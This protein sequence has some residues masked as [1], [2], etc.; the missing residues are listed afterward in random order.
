MTE[1]SIQ[2]TD[3]DVPM[4]AKVQLDA[5]SYDRHHL[6]LITGDAIPALRC[7]P[8]DCIN[9]I[10][11]SPPYFWVRDYG[12]EN[13]IGHEDTVRQY[14]TRLADVFDEVLRVL[15]PNGVCYVNIGDTYYSGNGQPHGRDPRS[16]SRNFMRQKLRPVDRSGWDIPKKSLIGIPW[17]L[18]FE[19]QK[20]NWALR[21]DIIWARSN[22][23]SEPSA[24]DRPWRQHEHLFL[25]AKNRFYS[26]DR[27]ALGGDED[28]WNISIERSKFNKE[29][30]APFPT[31]LVERCIATGAPPGGRVLDPF[32]GSGTTVITAMHMGRSC[33]GVD[34]KADYV[35]EIER[36]ICE[37][38]AT[39]EPWEETLSF[40]ERP[41]VELNNW[42]GHLSNLRKPGGP[43]KG[44]IE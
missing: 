40:L 31:K 4:T 30:N 28:V 26:Y 43:S 9:V 27:S 19:M 5:F 11:T 25:F 38:G 3:S 22:A 36:V 16:P 33:I 20:R 35:R 15:H 2:S 24:R 7:L 12:V 17:Q 37:I 23:F 32:A 1:S 42:Q 39:P 21:S 8:N 6:G 13:Q 41:C 18:A 29:H 34:I 10:V 14:I 44:R